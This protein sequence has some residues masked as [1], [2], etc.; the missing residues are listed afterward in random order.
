MQLKWAHSLTYN[1][2]KLTLN[3]GLQP[4]VWWNWLVLAP[5]KAD[6]VMSSQLSIQWHPVGTLK[7]VTLGVFIP[8]ESGNANFRELIQG[9]SQP[10]NIYYHTTDYDSLTGHE[11]NSVNCDQYFGRNLIERN[12]IKISAS[13]VYCKK[14]PVPFQEEISTK[15]KKRVTAFLYNFSS[16]FIYL[17]IYIPDSDIKYIS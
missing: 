7:L 1:K 8:W 13:I 6:C 5:D 17:Y 12:R 3:C 15:E 2:Y 9:Q 14:A 16:S 4:V 10:L 11:I